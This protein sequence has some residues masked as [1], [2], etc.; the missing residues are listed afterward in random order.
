MCSI[1]I[2]MRI[3]IICFLFIGYHTNYIVTKI[4]K[5]MI[6]FK[7]FFTDDVDKCKKLMN[8]MSHGYRSIY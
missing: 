2:D 4:V 8:C 5:L 6:M 3:T 1:I 7:H